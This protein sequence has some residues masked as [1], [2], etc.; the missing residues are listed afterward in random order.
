MWAATAAIAALAALAGLARAA[1]LSNGCLS[2]WDSS[3]D[4]FDNPNVL[5]GYPE[6]TQVP[7][8]GANRRER[9]SSESR[10]ARACRRR[11]EG[12]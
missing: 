9:A 7:W 1:T 5:S 6:G 2:S 11:L 4:Y 10:G 3:T 12:S 8:Q